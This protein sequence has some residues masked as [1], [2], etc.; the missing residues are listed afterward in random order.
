M[1]PVGAGQGSDEDDPLELLRHFR[2]R[3]LEVRRIS[4]DAGASPGG[5]FIR[6]MLE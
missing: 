6:K 4:R 5:V 3:P 2:E 1:V